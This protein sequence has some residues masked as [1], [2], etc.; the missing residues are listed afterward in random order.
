MASLVSDLKEQYDSRMIIFDVPPILQTDD[1]MLSSDYFDAT[2]LVLEDGKNKEVEIKKA[3]Q[4]LDGQNLIGTV[5]NKSEK[6]PT[7]QNY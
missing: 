7:H 2:L 3:I 5:L 4:L 6:Q 1:V